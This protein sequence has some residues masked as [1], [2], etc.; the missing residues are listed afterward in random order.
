V[1]SAD[2][3]DAQSTQLW[4]GEDALREQCLAALAAVQ[5]GY[6]DLARAT[7]MRADL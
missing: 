2:P 1:T 5:A 3:V 6:A 7:A 4:G